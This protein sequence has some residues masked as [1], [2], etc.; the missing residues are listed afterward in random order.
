MADVGT[1]KR[2]VDSRTFGILALA[3]ILSVGAAEFGAVGMDFAGL[4]K[5]PASGS[6]A[7]KE[8]CI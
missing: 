4:R 6:G 1:G 7:G 2:S 5:H 3:P 8:H